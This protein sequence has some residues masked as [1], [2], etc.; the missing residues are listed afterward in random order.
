M[1]FIAATQLS[2]DA[3]RRECSLSDRL[4]RTGRGARRLIQTVACGL[5]TVMASVGVAT[6]ADD[7]PANWPVYHG[8]SKSTRFSALT[9]INKSN[10]S[11]LKVAWIHQPGEIAGGLQA[12]PIVIDGV[13]YY[14]SANNKVQA[15]DAGTGKELW[16]YQPKLD[17]VVNE[18]FFTASSRGVTVG[19]GKVYLATL[20]GRIIALDQKTGT[21]VWS[22]Q[23]VETRKQSGNNFTSP[24]TLA[25]E[26]LA[27]APTSGDSAQRGKIYGVDANT[28][29]KLWEF[30]TIKDDQ[31][32]WPG[33]SGDT[34]GGG[35]WLPGTYDRETDTLYW[36][37]GNPAPDYYG[38]D[39]KGDN[40]YT[41]SVVA[42]DPKTGKLKWHRQEL[43]HDV[44]DFDST[45]ETVLFE[46]DGKKLLFHPT[47]TGFVWVMERDSGKLVN[48]WPF[49]QTFNFVKTIDPKTG[50]LIGRRDP[51]LGKE[52]LICPWILGARSWNHGAYSPDTG[53]WYN[54]VMEACNVVVT[55]KQDPKKL[56]LAELYYGVESAKMVPPPD[57]EASGR[58]EARD[59]VS[60]KVKWSVSYAI[61]GLGCVLATAGGLVFNGDVFGTLNAYDA[62]NGKVVWS[63]NMG[64]G[65]R[66]GIVSY[67]VNGKQY[68]VVSSGMYSHAVDFMPPVFP[69]IRDANGGAALIAFTLE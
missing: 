51:V 31:K 45:Y 36:G 62:D 55:A 65:V 27:I 53:L 11:R 57:R 22:I 58:F 24:P 7:N 56:G 19:L 10:V 17:P 32:S 50:E 26:V 47:K 21:E 44:W 1:N 39:R 29:K 16:R 12:T 34:G 25:G 13:L 6:A 2:P 4:T 52:T 20:D 9:S 46:R 69:K 23:L 33:T 5:M 15:L 61:P 67:A 8:N 60:G 64:S 37:I 59:P 3:T 49:S 28:G 63:F 18:I 42:L 40:L 43:P 14:S 38:E 41:D 48:V 30:D 68:I 35:G 66:G 54:N